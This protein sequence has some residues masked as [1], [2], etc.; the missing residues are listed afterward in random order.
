M[1]RICGC[2]GAKPQLLQ[3]R[4]VNRH[5]HMDR[6]ADLFFDE[7]GG[8]FGAA[9]ARVADDDELQVARAEGQQRIVVQRGQN[10]VTDRLLQP[11]RDAQN[12]VLHVEGVQVEVQ[13]RDLTLA[14]TLTGQTQVQVQ[15]L[16]EDAKARA[17]I[18]TWTSTWPVWM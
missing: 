1:F 12:E 17:V 15:E 9:V 10:H 7:V 11:I 14:P 3:D 13:E 16:L 8:E 18:R 6:V 2:S 4:H 5:R